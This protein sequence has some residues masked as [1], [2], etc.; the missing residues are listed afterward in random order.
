MSKYKNGFRVGLNL[1]LIG[2]KHSPWYFLPQRLLVLRI[3]GC[4][5][6]LLLLQTWTVFQVARS[7]SN[8]WSFR[9]E[10]SSSSPSLH[11]SIARQFSLNRTPSFERHSN[12][13]ALSNGVR[14]CLSQAV[15]SLIS[16]TSECRRYLTVRTSPKTAPRSCAAGAATK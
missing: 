9:R 11:S 13:N 14:S 6:L 4:R 1:N 12:F 3:A 2:C 5:I 16:P 15:V 10:I 7:Y 8:G